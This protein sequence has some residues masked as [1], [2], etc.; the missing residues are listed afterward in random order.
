MAI[1]SPQPCHCWLVTNLQSVNFYIFFL[2]S[3]ELLLSPVA[4]VVNLAFCLNPHPRISHLFLLKIYL[5]LVMALI[6]KKYMFLHLLY[7]LIFLLQKSLLVIE[8]LEGKG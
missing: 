4:P 7:V 3:Q 8:N 2:I 5:A 1:F 6:F